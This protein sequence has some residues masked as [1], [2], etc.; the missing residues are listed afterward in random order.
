MDELDIFAAIGG[1]EEDMLWESPRRVL[2]RRWGLI[3][4]MV[5]L[6]VLS[7]CA[8]PVV[9]RTFRAV[10]GGE[11]ELT[12]RA[13]RTRV[14]LMDNETGEIMVVSSSAEDHPAEYEI[15]LGITEG[16]ARPETLE[17]LYAPGWIPEDYVNFF[18]QSEENCRILLYSTGDRNG[19]LGSH[20]EFRQSLLPEGDP[21]VFTERLY[22]FR[23]IVVND[24]ES[25]C[26]TYGEAT[27]LE[28]RPREN[29]LEMLGQEA[30]AFGA[31]R[32]LYWSDGAYLFR[33]VIPYEMDTGTVTRII[34]SVQIV[35][36]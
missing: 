27:V 29:T 20:V 32:Y 22:D 10:S 19:L 7:A 18:D 12:Q 30:F 3:A 23:G 1:V 16:A 11:A 4:A 2:P 15:T 17:E 5:T 13:Q 6:A 36:Q 34:D 8:A 25:A 28:L 35:E 26:V 31:R 21:V 33:L 9:M 24:M 14:F